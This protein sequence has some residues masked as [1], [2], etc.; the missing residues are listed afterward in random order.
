[1]SDKAL[2]VDELE[3][4]D[5]ED[6]SSPAKVR[7]ELRGLKEKIEE[8][9]AAMAGTPGAKEVKDI[10][11]QLE[12]VLVTVGEMDGNWKNYTQQLEERIDE[13]QTDAALLGS[14]AADQPIGIKALAD[15]IVQSDDYK[16]LF[17]ASGQKTHRREGWGERTEVGSLG[18]LGVKAASPVTISDLSGVNLQAYR[19]GVWTERDWMMDLWSRLPKTVV[20]NATSYVI[21]RETVASRYGAVTSTLAADIDGDPTPKSTATFADVEGFTAGTY[22]RFFNSTGGVLGLAKIISIDIGTKIVTFVTDSL[23]WNATTGWR[24]CS[25]NYGYTAEEALKPSAHLGTDNL[26]YTLRTL[27]ALLPTTVNAINT[28]PGLEALIENKLPREWA[29]NLSYHLLYGAT[30][31]AQLQGFRTYTGADVQSY[32]W[33]GGTL[34]D[35]RIDALVRAI[36]MIPW[37]API[38]VVMSQADLPALLLLKGTDGHYIQSQSFGLMT[39]QQLG[40]S[41]FLG[42]WELVFDNACVSGDFTPVNFADASEFVDQDTASLQW[43]YINDDF[44]KNIIRARYEGTV[45]HAVKSGQNFVIGQWDNAPGVI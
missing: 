41:W 13:L 36:M 26:E 14:K 34:G 11:S 5:R 45:A 7:Q 10:R 21:P 27:A 22:V 23:T 24:V 8:V 20:K 3:T 37:T 40:A 43:G 25:V 16:S 4:K 31:S 33:S 30:A 17:D 19:P 28:I 32:S 15:E 35:N 29:R 38:S 44:A 39:L 18:V 1:M 42:P 6:N 12:T 9:S 2:N